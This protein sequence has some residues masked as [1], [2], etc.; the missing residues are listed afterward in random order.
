MAKETDSLHNLFCQPLL[1]GVGRAQSRASEATALHDMESEPLSL[2]PY[3]LNGCHSHC[4]W[5]EA[6]EIIQ[7]SPR[8]H[9][10]KLRFRTCLRSHSALWPRGYQH[11]SGGVQE[12][13]NSETHLPALGSWA[14][15][16]TL[17]S[18]IVH[19][20]ICRMERVIS[21][22]GYKEERAR[23]QH[24]SAHSKCSTNSKRTYIWGT[25]PM[26][27]SC[28]ALHRWHLISFLHQV[29]DR[30]HH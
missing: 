9:T 5:T 18:Q 7:S 10:G 17:T 19:L 15:L 25:C 13:W 1:Q 24:P 2:H 27:D 29:G 20:L 4:K 6:L 11:L 23:V 8:E 21:G 12:K 30:C 14:L 28:M 26:R 16:F 22:L 3:V